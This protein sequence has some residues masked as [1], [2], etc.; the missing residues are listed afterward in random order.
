MRFACT[1]QRAAESWLTTPSLLFSSFEPKFCTVKKLTVTSVAL[2]PNAYRLRLRPSRI[3]AGRPDEGV[4]VLRDH[5]AVERRPGARAPRARASTWYYRERSRST[6][7]GESFCVVTTVTAPSGATAGRS[8]A[9]CAAP[10]GMG[11]VGA[12]SV[13]YAAGGASRS[14]RARLDW[15]LP[16]GQAGHERQHDGQRDGQRP[17]PPGEPGG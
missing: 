8:S 1:V 6:T 9:S 2:P 10:A 7:I 11:A 17:P 16:G 12:L 4:A 15:T 14:R 13:E 3:S 5:L